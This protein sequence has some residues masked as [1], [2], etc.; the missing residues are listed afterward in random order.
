M[1]DNSS[2]LTLS[3]TGGIPSD[4]V[5]EQTHPSPQGVCFAVLRRTTLGSE[6]VTDGAEPHELCLTIGAQGEAQA[7]QHINHTEPLNQP[8]SCY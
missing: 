4:R 6:C 3:N 5:D 2:S 1:T 7:H 8:T